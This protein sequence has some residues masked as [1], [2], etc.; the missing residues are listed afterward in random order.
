MSHFTTVETKLQDLVLLKKVLKYL[1]YKLKENVQHVRGYRGEKINAD[2]VL[3]TKSSYDIGLV[4]T[5][6]GYGFVADWEGVTTHAGIEQDQFLKTVN[7]KY[8]YEKVM[9]EIKKK[10]YTVAE[11][12]T[13]QQQHIHITLRKWA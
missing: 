11:E 1:G 13:D 8:P 5:A 12:K 2:L 6:T 10:G 4:K 7:K 3:D 9:Q